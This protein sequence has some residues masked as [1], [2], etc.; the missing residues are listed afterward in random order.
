MKLFLIAFTIL[1]A[2]FSFAAEKYNLSQ[3]SSTV[4]FQAVGKPS[5]LKI[6]GTGGKLIGNIEIELN[7]ILG[8]F[9]VVL[10]DLTTGIELRDKHMKEKYLEVSKFPEASFN[11]SKIA[12]PT[13]FLTERK[14]FSAV[15]FEGK[16]KIKNMEKDIAGTADVDTTDITQIKVSTEFKTGISQYQIDIPT[17]LGIKVADEVIIKTSMNLKK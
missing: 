4:E 9:K 16:M 17:Y 2:S 14:V 15:P 11:I 13:N 12:L 1:S 3:Q 6:N 8:E 5:M 7:H 10:S